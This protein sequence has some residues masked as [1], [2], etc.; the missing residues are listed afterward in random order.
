VETDQLHATSLRRTDKRGRFSTTQQQ[1]YQRETQLEAEEEAT[2]KPSITSRVYKVFRCPGPPC[3]LG[4]H[5]WVDPLTKKHYY[6][7]YCKVAPL[8]GH[9]STC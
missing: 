2:G 7:S 1:L 8:Q 5:C 9:T 4:P 3:N 6:S